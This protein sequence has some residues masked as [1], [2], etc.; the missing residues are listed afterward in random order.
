MNFKKKWA[1][2]DDNEFGFLH[3]TWDMVKCPNWN[4]G[5]GLMKWSGLKR[6]LKMTKELRLF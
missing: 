6:D 2:K 4:I 5:L 3:Y 1:S